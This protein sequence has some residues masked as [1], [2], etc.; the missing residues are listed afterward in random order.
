MARK[1]VHASSY[2]AQIDAGQV[3][4]PVDR[5]FPLEQIAAAH[6]YAEGPEVRGTVVVAC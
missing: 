5:V 1:T 4:V 3:R 6:E 2:S